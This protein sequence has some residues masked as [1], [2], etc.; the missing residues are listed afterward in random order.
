[1]TK[2]PTQFDDEILK[3]T[4]QSLLEEIKQWINNKS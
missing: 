4:A 1:M 2:R 3:L